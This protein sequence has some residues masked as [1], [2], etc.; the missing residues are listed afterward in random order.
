MESRR[1]L[2]LVVDDSPANL[3]ALNAVLGEDYDLVFATSGQEALELARD[4]LPDLILLDVVMPGMDGYEACRLL[5]DDEKTAGTPVIFVTAMDH[6]EDEAA[7]LDAGAIDYLTKPIRAS[8]VRARVRN[9]LEL[10]RARDLLESLS[11]TDPLTGLPNRRQFDA[12]LETEIR[13]SLRNTAYLGLLMC[14][15]D[16]FKSYNDHHGHP[17]GDRCLQE[18]AAVFQETFRRA[19]ELPARYGGE[20]F[21]V[22]LPSATPTDAR[23]MGERVREAVEARRIPHP[24]SATSPWVT[25]SV[26]VASL[27]VTTEVSPSWLVQRADVALYAS[28]KSGRNRVTVAEVDL[29]RQAVVAASGF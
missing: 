9:H 19:G 29:G 16:H 4:Q 27:L 23:N 14:D 8:I 2:I 6:E 10:K 15:L 28:K 1:P 18:V 13:R 12:A 7:G 5:A 17:A 22:I 25:L 26:G 24:R 11:I 21:A 3:E 20:E